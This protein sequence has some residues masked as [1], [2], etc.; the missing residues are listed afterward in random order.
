MLGPLSFRKERQARTKNKGCKRQD[1]G[2]AAGAGPAAGRRGVRPHYV[3]PRGG[4]LRSP[5]PLPPRPCAAGSG[6]RG[7]RGLEVQERLGAS[8]TP[9]LPLGG[10]RSGPGGRSPAASSLLPRPRGPARGY[11]RP[12]PR[13]PRTRQGPG[14]VE[15]GVPPSSRE[16]WERR[17]VGRAMETWPMSGREGVMDGPRAPPQ[18]RPGCGGPGR[19]PPPRPRPA[20]RFPSEVA[21]ALRARQRRVAAPPD[22]PFAAGPEAGPSAPRVGRAAASSLRLLLPQGRRARLPRH[23]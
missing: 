17:E 5:R 3:T 6:P 12:S 20:L 16:N 2:P 7:R 15:R 21:A 4:R 19:R 22:F 8:G 1:G 9:R 13:P 11:P 10:G 14:T 18:P 23:E